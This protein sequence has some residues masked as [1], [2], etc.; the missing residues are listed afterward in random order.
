MRRTSTSPTSTWCCPTTLPVSTTRRTTSP[1]KRGPRGKPPSAGTTSTQSSGSPKF[2][3][4]EQQR[5]PIHRPGLLRVAAEQRRFQGQNALG[6]LITYGLPCLTPEL[7][8]TI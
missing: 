5:H 3:R 1:R 7:F 6:R 4:S 8:T 2:E